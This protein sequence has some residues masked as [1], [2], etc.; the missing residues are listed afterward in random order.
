[1]FPVPLQKEEE[2]LDTASDRIGQNCNACVGSQQMVFFKSMLLLGNSV[3]LILESRVF[4][5]L[6]HFPLLFLCPSQVK[7]K[8]E[9]RW[10][11][12]RSL[13]EHDHSLPPLALAFSSEPTGVCRFLRLWEELGWR[14]PDR[15]T[16]L[17]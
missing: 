11:E 10:T 2:I 17:S 9:Q 1:M 5:D 13:R 16:L 8:C 7:K 4:V 6:H 12:E 3:Y 14:K 15:R